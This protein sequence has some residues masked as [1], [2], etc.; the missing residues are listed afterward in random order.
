MKHKLIVTMLLLI[1]IPL[2]GCSANTPGDILTDRDPVVEAQRWV[3]RGGYSR[4]WIINNLLNAGF[5]YEEAIYGVD[6]C[7]AD[8]NEQAVRKAIEVLSELPRSRQHLI[9]WLIQPELFTSDQAV[10]AADH[11][12]VDY[13]DMAVLYAY[14]FINSVYE[15]DYDRIVGRMLYDLFTYDQAVYAANIVCGGEM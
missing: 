9:N 2:V 8:W 11:C 5:T 10:Y 14:N 1:T 13:Y 3:E 12:G 6:N 7:G 4:Q 15:A